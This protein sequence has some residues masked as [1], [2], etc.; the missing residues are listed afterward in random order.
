MGAPIGGGTQTRNEADNGCD[1]D[2]SSSRVPFFFFFVA[3][4]KKSMYVRTKHLGKRTFVI[5]RTYA[6]KLLSLRPMCCCL[7]IGGLDA[8]GLR[9]HLGSQA[10]QDPPDCLFPF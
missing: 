4:A 8:E 5:D 10:C 3:A 9:A 2:A 6:A 1:R 7:H